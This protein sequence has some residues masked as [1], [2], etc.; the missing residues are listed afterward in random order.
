MFVG[1]YIEEEHAVVVEIC[2]IGPSFDALC[3]LHSDEGIGA[4]C[5][6]GECVELYAFA[7]VVVVVVL[8]IY[9]EVKLVVA[10]YGLMED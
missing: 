3:G 9:A 2:T 10:A 1:W 7:V 6:L 5:D 4:M 8:V